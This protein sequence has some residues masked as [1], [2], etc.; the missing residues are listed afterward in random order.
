MH[1]TFVMKKK[2]NSSNGNT[3][4]IFN[5]GMILSG[6]IVHIPEYIA[7]ESTIARYKVADIMTKLINLILFKVQSIEN[8]NCAING[9]NDQTIINIKYKYDFKL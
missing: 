3:L 2:K 4:N 7:M 1:N 5:D 9:G 8:I 6:L